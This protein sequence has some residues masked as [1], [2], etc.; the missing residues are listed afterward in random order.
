VGRGRPIGAFRTITAPVALAG[1]VVALTVGAAFQPSVA[2][3]AVAAKLQSPSDW[4]A[5]LCTGLVGWQAAALDARDA[6]FPLVRTAPADK[7]GVKTA[8]LALDA[9]LKPPTTAI[10]TVTKNL[11]RRQPKGKNGA[12]LGDALATDVAKLADA[13]HAARERA[14]ALKSATPAKYATKAPLVLTKLDKDLTKIEKPISKLDR[15]VSKSSVDAPIRSTPA[16]RR[17]GFEWS[18]LNANLGTTPPS[19]TDPAAP[20]ADD[21]TAP[22]VLLP[23]NYRPSSD[24]AALAARTT[25]TGLGREYFYASEPQVLT[26]QPFASACPSA[27][28]STQQILG[29]FHDH[30]IW[31]LGVTRPELVTVVDVTAAHEMLHA[32]YDEMSSTTHADIDPKLSAL[33]DSTADVHIHQIVPIYEKRTPLN[34]ASE[35]HSLVGTQVGTLTPEL[36]AYYAQFFK[37]RSKIVG[38]YVAYISVFDNLLNRYHELDVQLGDLRDQINGLR[39]QAQA[40]G[41]EAQRLGAQIDALRAQGRVAESNTLVAPQNAAARNA[42]GLIAQSNGLVDQYNGLVDEINGISQQLGGLQGALRP[43]G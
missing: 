10:D 2:G 6:A 24:I 30:R 36:D 20:G 4:T 8:A 33:Y 15:R 19:V 5:Q 27:E 11:E 41:A 1:C 17:L 38:D 34:R 42:N 16:C 40:S 25:M 13:F 39:S 21:V 9:A 23:R 37:D 29:C 18:A 3:A 14:V 43:F 35:L 26:G 22:A 7:A 32:V 31:V 12:A 28:A